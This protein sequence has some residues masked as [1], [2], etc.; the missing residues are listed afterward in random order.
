M[1]MAICEC[2]YN[3]ALSTSR[4]DSIAPDHRRCCICSG[5]YGYFLPDARLPINIQ[6]LLERGREYSSLQQTGS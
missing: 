5:R 2:L 3:I 1:E 4:A 6:T